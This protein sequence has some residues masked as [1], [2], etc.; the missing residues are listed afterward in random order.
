MNRTYTLSSIGCLALQY[1]KCDLKP[2]NFLLKTIY[3]S[4]ASKAQITFLVPR[5]IP[6]LNWTRAQGSRFRLNQVH[7]LALQL[8]S[9]YV[10]LRGYQCKC[11]CKVV[12]FSSGHLINS[13]NVGDYY[14]EAILWIRERRD[15]HDSLTRTHPY[16]YPYPRKSVL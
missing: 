8:D 1:L 11:K 9:S 16:P 4:V 6:Q 3:N 2:I 14:M 13:V 12:D 5:E 7:I 10:T 15:G